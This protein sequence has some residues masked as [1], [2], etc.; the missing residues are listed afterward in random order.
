MYSEITQDE[1]NNVV[2]KKISEANEKITS[3]FGEANTGDLKSKIDS[4]IKAVFGDDFKWSE[5]DKKK[6]GELLKKS[7]S[8]E[9]SKV[10]DDIDQ[11]F[12]DVTSKKSSE[13]TEKVVEEIQSLLTQKKYDKVKQNMY[14]LVDKIDKIEKIPTYN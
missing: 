13:K 9:K 8:N 2:S 11:L 1:F 12:L 4:F 6:L 3:L 5:E 14:T 10:V 7:S